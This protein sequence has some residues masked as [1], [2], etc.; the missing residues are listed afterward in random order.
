MPA[1]SQ[2]RG[3]L[4]AF[5]AVCVVNVVAVGVGLEVVATATKPFIVGLLL[6]WG[7]VLIFV[8]VFLRL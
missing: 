3:V 4:A 1:L 7:P 5:L 2:P 6:V 8:C